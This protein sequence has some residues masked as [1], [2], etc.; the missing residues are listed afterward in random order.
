M[1]RPR[2]RARPRS[3]RR[4]ML[5]AR[6]ARHARARRASPHAPRQ[7]RPP[8]RPAAFSPSVTVRC[9]ATACFV[10]EFVRVRWCSPPHSHSPPS[11]R[12]FLKR[13]AHNL[14]RRVMRPIRAP[15]PHAVAD[16]PL[17]SPRR[18]PV[19]VG[20]SDRIRRIPPERRRLRGVHEHRLRPPLPRSVTVTSFDAAISPRSSPRSR[21]FR[22][23]SLSCS[24]RPATSAF[25]ITRIVV[26]AI[27]PPS[28]ARSSRYHPV[29][30]RHSDVAIFGEFLDLSLPRRPQTP[31]LAR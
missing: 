3:D 21:R 1:P 19:C 13:P 12:S 26:A 24:S 16:P 9:T 30:R 2:P 25:V 7:H 27:A 23:S 15:L 11:R 18:W 29:P 8:F 10:C 4:S 6:P 20:E 28:P 17:A 5:P 14:R 22:H 31:R